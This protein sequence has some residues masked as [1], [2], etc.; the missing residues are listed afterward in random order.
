MSTNSNSFATRNILLVCPCRR[1]NP[2]LNS[3]TPRNDRR[4]YVNV[5]IHTS[6][7]MYTH[8]YTRNSTTMIDCYIHTHVC[9]CMYV[10]ISVPCSIIQPVKI[11]YTVYDRERVRI[12]TSFLP[13]YKARNTNQSLNPNRHY[14][15]NVSEPPTQFRILLMV[16]RFRHCIF[17]YV[18][19]FLKLTSLDKAWKSPQITMYASKF[20]CKK[21]Y[22]QNA[23]W[24]SALTL[25]DPWRN[26]KCDRGRKTHETDRYR[27]TEHRS[28]HE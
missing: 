20:R 21:L 4:S 24:C 5:S 2:A 19:K 12:I 7:C 14:V 10:R 22:W 26:K 3:S 23:V 28:T 13:E 18:S 11:R 25:S 6:V 27:V 16:T 9:T 17:P 15:T 8:I 1:Y